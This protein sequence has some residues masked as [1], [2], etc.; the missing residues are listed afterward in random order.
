[1]SKTFIFDIDGTITNEPNIH[2][3]K[4]N[5]AT[6]NWKMI[7]KINELSE[8]NEIIFFSSRYEEDR[9]ITLDWLKKYNIKYHKLILG[10][11]LGDYYIDDKNISIQNF[12]K[13]F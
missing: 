9:E 13:E 10:K 1:M 4:F 3:K 12:L 6:P 11:P 2:F 8:E 5:Q 7:Q